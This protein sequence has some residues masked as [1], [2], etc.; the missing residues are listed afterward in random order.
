MLL[1]AWA[2]ENLEAEPE[3]RTVL[4]AS[5]TIISYLQSGFVP[6]AAY[7]AS[8]APNWHIGAKLYLAFALVVLA[9]FISIHFGLKW[10]AKKKAKKLEDGDQASTGSGT[11]A[12]DHVRE[13]FVEKV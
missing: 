3:I 13:Q 4:F 12:I 6:I 2:A 10:E 8:Q 1:T 11:E 9:M 5:G 7:P